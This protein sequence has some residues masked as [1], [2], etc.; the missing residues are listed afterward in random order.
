MNTLILIYIVFAAAIL[1][2]AIT[3]SMLALLGR[4]ERRA[5]IREPHKRAIGP[6]RRHGSMN[7]RRPEVRRRRASQRVAPHR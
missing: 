6:K 2:M 7:P 4:A 1:W 5:G 3:L